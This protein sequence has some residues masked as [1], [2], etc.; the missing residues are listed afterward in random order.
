MRARIVRGETLA[1][2]AAGLDL[3]RHVKLGE[4]ELKSGGCLRKSR[5]A[6]AL[7][8]LLGAIYLDG[9]F[10]SCERVILDLCAPLVSDL[11]DVESLKDSKTRLQ[12]WLQARGRPLPVYEL[13]SESGHDHEKS[14]IIRCRLQDSGDA[15]TAAGS[16]LRKAEQAA[17]GSLMDRLTDTGAE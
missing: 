10:E 17:A 16:S 7:E 9:G 11:P 13:V 2:L 12:E 8:A 3:G 15:V 1:K 6:D 5:L 14:F 4:G